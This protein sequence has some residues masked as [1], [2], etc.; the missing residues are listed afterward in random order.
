[1]VVVAAEP[2]LQAGMGTNSTFVL[3]LY[4]IPGSNYVIQSSSDLNGNQWQL[5]TSMTLSN[6]ATPIFVGGVSSNPP[7]QFYRAYQQ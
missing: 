7:V 4:G 2:L 3:T 6:V 5:D 1:V